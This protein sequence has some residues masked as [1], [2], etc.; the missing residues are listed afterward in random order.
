MKDYFKFISDCF[1]AFWLR[2]SV[3]LYLT[4]Q[5]R[6]WHHIPPDMMYGE[7]YTTTYVV[8][9]HNL[10]LI[11]K[12]YQI[13]PHGGVILENKHLVSLKMSMSHETHTDWGT[14]PDWRKQ[15]RFDKRLKYMILG[16]L[17]LESALTGANSKVRINQQIR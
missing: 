6:N 14:I 15:K 17:L 1:S 7:G 5:S 16:F 9:V 13:N 2:W 11:V 8:F 12:K 3:N 4:L 10:Y